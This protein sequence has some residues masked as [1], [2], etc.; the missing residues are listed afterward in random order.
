[1]EKEIT[2]RKALNI[3]NRLVGEIG[4]LR[5]K[6]MSL[7]NYIEGQT[8]ENALTDVKKLNEELLNKEC[9][10]IELKTKIHQKNAES[11]TYETITQISE[12]KS[13]IDYYTSLRSQTTDN[14]DKNIYEWDATHT[15]R[16]IT[17]VDKYRAHISKEQCDALVSELKGKLENAFDTV[18][19]FN[20][21][22]R[23]SI[24][25]D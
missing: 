2:I 13:L 6:I 19:A 7:N 25:L 18:E 22:T 11:K 15:A 16:T 17:S 23:I 21:S 3:K 12:Y 9:K 14:V 10:L 8:T 24:D 4:D 20:A 5:N 1:M